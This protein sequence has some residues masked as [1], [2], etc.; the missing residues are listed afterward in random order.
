MKL[1]VASDLHLEGNVD[2]ADFGIAP[3]LDADMLI[4]AGDIARGAR[5]SRHFADWSISVVYVHGNL[6]ARAGHMI[7]VPRSIE[8]QA[9][10]TNIVCL[11]HAIHTVGIVRFLGCCLWTDFEFYGAPDAAKGEAR[12]CMPE[13]ERLR[14][15]DSRAFSP[16]CS[17]KLHQKARAW[18]AAKLR[19]MFDGK[20]VV[21]T[22]H[23]PHPLSI[24]PQFVGSALAPCFASDLSS[25]MQHVDL[26][27]HGHTHWSCDYSVGRCRV[28]CN[29]RG[30]RNILRLEAGALH[31]NATFNPQLLVTI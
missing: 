5:A 16:D 30:Y 15:G 1:H 20:T 9:L 11:K 8:M 19:K 27:I 24:L 7:D 4:L 12:P 10:G 13:Y 17:A 25:L 28:L 18:L 6:E 22:H 31:E 14:N 23:A 21:V 26:W 2:K 29:A 3:A